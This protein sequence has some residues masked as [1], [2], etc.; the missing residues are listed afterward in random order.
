MFSL[1]RNI[2]FLH[3]NKLYLLVYQLNKQEIGAVE[4]TQKKDWIHKK[5]YALYLE[6]KHKSKPV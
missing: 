6:T 2:S 3:L 5:N 4:F 1:I